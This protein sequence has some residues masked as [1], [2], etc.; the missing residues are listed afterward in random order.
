ML[1][2]LKSKEKVV[3]FKQSNRAI[4]EK[5]AAMVYLAKDAQPHVTEPIAALCEQEQI[6]VEWV[7]SMAE[8]G[9]ACQIDVG[10][11]VVTLLKDSFLK[12]VPF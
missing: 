4:K 9:R 8:L 6:P 2:T 3:G 12:G 7:E 11:A 1:E 10:A 5:K